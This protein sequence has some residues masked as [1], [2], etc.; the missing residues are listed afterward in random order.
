MRR[1]LLQLATELA[2][3]GEPY[4]IATVVRREA[5]SSAQP[6][7][8][9]IITR[10]GEFHGWLGGSCTRSTVVAEANKAMH[11]GVPRLIS[12]TPDPEAQVRPGVVTLPMTCHSG[13]TVDVYLE[14]MLAAPR[15]VVY[16][17]SP[18]AQAVARVG[19]V[20]GYYVEAVD[21]DATEALFPGADHITTDHTSP[22]LLSRCEQTPE[23]LV[24]VVATLGLWDEEA[25]RSALALRPRYV[26]LV[27]SRTRFEKMHSLLHERGVTR[28][29][30]DR[31]H[32]PAGIDIGA[33][34]PEEIALTIL[35]EVVQKLRSEP[36][37]VT[38][39]ENATA[40]DSATQP[41]T[42]DPV[43]GMIVD[44]A[45]T[46]LSADFGG[47]TYYFCCGGCREQFLA[48]PTKFTTVAVDTAQTR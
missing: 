45:T 19:K 26:G 46:R 14:P 22:E 1:E 40:T 7:N 47:N 48:D 9:A 6:G 5:P 2:E 23:R 10:G 32:C 34:A 13:G 16:G 30:L 29:Q 42:I 41:S 37:E 8:T 4:V 15:L 18:I 25:L 28:E 36:S 31:V 44:P 43:C 17:I 38:E 21:L 24:T 39:P 35:C 11:N 3:R 20:L 12:I 33:V 27:A